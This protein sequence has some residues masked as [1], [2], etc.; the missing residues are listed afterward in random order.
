MWP[1]YLQLCLSLGLVSKYKILYLIF[2][3]HSDYEL[4]EILTK[5]ITTTISVTLYLV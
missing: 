3:D 5:G 1:V 2:L 4:P